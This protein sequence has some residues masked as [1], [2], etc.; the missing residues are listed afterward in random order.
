LW[1]QTGALKHIDNGNMDI[2]YAMA[3]TW[4]SL[5]DASGKSVYGNQT[6]KPLEGSGYM[7]SNEKARA[8]INDGTKSLM[9]Q[10]LLNLLQ[11]MQK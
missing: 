2:I 8:G 4:A 1:E 9:K 11:L 10:M 3:P 5:K 7:Q 6:V